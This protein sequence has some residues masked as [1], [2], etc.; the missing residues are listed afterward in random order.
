MIKF[1]DKT[2]KFNLMYLTQVL[3]I[4]IGC[5]II[6]ITYNNSYSKNNL[7]STMKDFNSGWYNSTEKN[8]T[9]GKFNKANGFSTKQY[10]TYKHK[11]DS[12]ISSKDT[13]CFRGLSTD[14]KIYIDGK[15]VLDT[16]YKKGIF[17]C[18]SPG[19][20]WYF[21]NFKESDIGKT[22]T[23]K[24]KPYYNDNSC[25]ITD[26]YVGDSAHYV[27]NIFIDNLVFFILCVLLIIIGIILFV[28]DI[29]IN[30]LQGLS[31][32][33]LLY[34][35]IFSCAL[36]VWCTTSTHLIE[37]IFNNSQM[38]QT[39]AC[40]ML[41]LLALPCIF[42]LDKIFDL[43]PKKY[44]YISAWII[45]GSYVLAWILQLT[46]IADFHQTLPLSYLNMIITL[47]FFIVL[48]FT[49]HKH[50]TNNIKEKESPISKTIRNTIFLLMIISVFVD[51]VLFIKGTTTP[52]FFVS[53]D[54]ILMLIY[55]SCIS[56]MNLF[57][58]IKNAEHDKFVKQLAYKDGLTNI[59]NRTAYIEKLDYIKEHIN[60]YKAVGIV[61]LDVNNLKKVNDT[62]G[63]IQGDELIINSA[64]L[65]TQSFDNFST[66][67][68]IG[69]DEFA[70]IIE[71]PNAEAVSKISLMQFN[72]NVHNHN[73]FYSKNF[74]ISIAHGEAFY[75]ANKSQS[76]DDVVK[77]ADMN[78][79]KNKKNMKEEM[80][81]DMNQNFNKNFDSVKNK[82]IDN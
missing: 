9:L 81:K 23:I 69:G 43:Q 47:I 61:I 78:M 63:H 12:N 25:Y 52:G 31:S 73:M 6:T 20:V 13:L 58:T 59:A 75:K 39:L 64:K 17:T 24:V 1:K 42:F 82:Q 8:L 62:Y 16:P 30:K 27:Y 40:N 2:T 67:Y 15:L 72:V 55:L 4:F 70:V 21:Y 35:G 37:F 14:I 71:A 38:V 45:I 41:Y 65:I 32:H 19:S 60:N 49:S 48:M 66:V 22:M 76:L 10:N 80:K 77:Q 79:Y 46:D 68:R 33:S 53:C 36:G 18:K 57:K 28:A 26:M 29:L 50:A 34:I 51:M 5:L 7:L 44:I 11:I 3:I 56:A 74:D 54:L